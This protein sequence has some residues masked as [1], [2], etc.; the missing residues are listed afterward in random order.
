[1]PYIDVQDIREH[2]KIGGRVSPAQIQELMTEVES[3]V[4]MH[5]NVDPLP[6]NS[7]ILKSIIRELTMAKVILDALSPTSD[8]LARAQ[9]HNAL[10]MRMLREVKDEGLVPSNT[11]TRDVTKEVY[12][13][14]PEPFFSIMDF[15]V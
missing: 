15:Q 5:L 2:L 10:G 14:Y 4:K 6:E 11:G 12:N 1:M 9:M 3:Y 13:P 7:N 8:D